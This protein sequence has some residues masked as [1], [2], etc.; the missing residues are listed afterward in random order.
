MDFSQYILMMRGGTPCASAL[1][2]ELGNLLGGHHLTLTHQQLS[3]SPTHNILK[4]HSV[5][6]PSAASQPAGGYRGACS[7]GGFSRHITGARWRWQSSP[8][9]TTDI[10][11]GQWVPGGPPLVIANLDGT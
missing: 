4:T 11:S 7:L 6:G 2:G 5:G 3:T 9:D 8:V 10:Y 1:G